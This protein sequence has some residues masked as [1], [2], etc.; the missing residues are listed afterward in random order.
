MA[1]V[2]KRQRQRRELSKD[3]SQS[4]LSAVSAAQRRASWGQNR[5]K[6]STRATTENKRTPARRKVCNRNCDK[7]K[8][9]SEISEQ[10]TSVV[11]SL[12]F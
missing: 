11:L 4:A 6:E 5:K 8:L 1:N 3:Q 9:Y 7:D 10:H 2:R 12:Q